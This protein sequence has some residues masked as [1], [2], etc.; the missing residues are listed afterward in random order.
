MSPDDAAQP[1]R[2]P[3]AP[4]DR[5]AERPRETGQPPAYG[6]PPGYGPPPYAPPPGQPPYG[7]PP[8]QYPP[9][10]WG[11]G[12]PWGQQQYGQPWGPQW[13]QPGAGTW[14]WAPPPDPRAQ[15]RKR[16]LAFGALGGVVLLLVGVLGAAVA[17]ESRRDDRVRAAVARVVPELSAF[18]EA[19]RGLAFKEEV[20]VEVLG[21]DD[22]LDALYSDG[23]G[24]HEEQ[25]DPEPTLKALG[26]LPED[27]DLEE[28]VTGAL[29]EGVVG[30][31]DPEDGRLVVRGRDLDA[32]VEMTIV[33]EL[34]HALQDQHFELDRPEVDEADDERS[35]AFD[36][37]AEGDATRVEEAWYAEQ[38]PERQSQ[39]DG[40]YGG[41]SEEQETDVVDVLLG[42][43][44][45]VGPTYVEDLLSE[46]G[47]PALDAAFT[48][49]PTTTEQILYGADRPDPVAVAE[50]ELPGD[51]LDRGAL[52]TLGLSLV[53]GED[54]F[55][56]DGTDL[57]DGDRYLTTKDGDRTCTLAHVA[58]PD[59]AEL[60]SRLADWAE[61][62][63]DAEVG[64]GPGGT[65]RLQACL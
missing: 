7:P 63:P 5:D 10:P 24:D 29:D 40:Y 36:A 57:W 15:R 38:S 51:V 9:P 12:Q 64:E 27:T 56:G 54:V 14:G 19:E 58:A 34:T 62:Q 46:G 17:L 48:D 35:I 55:G 21:D 31:Y 13:G 45:F 11:A 25:L 18:V 50:P 59:P 2:D 39:V 33:H 52:G 32:F 61:V 42:F 4:P 23:G 37:L 26:L 43:P 44:Y 41:G 6:P 49:P 28:E 20:D 47:Q 60:R 22:F 16:L 3:W 65:V 30:F 53:L 8:G 1:P